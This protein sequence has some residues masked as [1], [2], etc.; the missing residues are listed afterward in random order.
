MTTDPEKHIVLGNSFL[1]DLEYY[2][3]E[4]NKITFIIQGQKII[5][6]IC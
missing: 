1:N 2:R 6:E 4:P 3:I 5:C